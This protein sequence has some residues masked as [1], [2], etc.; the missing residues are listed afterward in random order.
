MSAFFSGMEIAF[1]SCNRVFLEIEKNKKG[2]IAKVLKF[3]TSKP[4]KFITTMLVGNNFCL[5]IYGIFMGD[6]IIEILFSDLNTGPLPF[7]ILFIQTLISTF[8]IL[9]TAEFLPKVFFQLYANQ[10]VKYFALPSSFFYTFFMPISLLI[11]KITD[12]SLKFF[13]NSKSDKI[14]LTFSKN[15]LGEYIE[16]QVEA[17]ENKDQL[18]SEIE[19]FQNALEFSE[20]KVREVMIPRAE[21]IGINKSENIL[22]LSALFESTGYSKIP[23]YDE[24]IDDVI[25]FVHA[26]E[27]LKKP[28]SIIEILIPIEY[29]H[30]PNLITDVLKKLTIK[31]KTI[32]V[33]LDEYGGTA[34]LLTVED[35]IEELF[36]EIE[37]EYDIIEH[38]E[39]KINVNSFEF[40]ARLEI[41]YLIRK[42]KL[43]LPQDENY[44]TLGGLIFHITGEIP[45]RDTTLSI[46]DLEIKV[47]SVLSNK[48]EKVAIKKVID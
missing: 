8:I 2:I 24:N 34:G 39:K 5:V 32:A 35:I 36:G 40:S 10:M 11:L 15:E 28:N 48:I 44:E 43:D 30:E 45:Q 7:N 47:V 13:S 41:D 17:V 12:S 19:F 29:V 37:D 1:I 14:Q 42:Y 38:Y 31:R 23:V 4:S 22:E 6:K 26:F 9:I 25:G 16:E 20:T 21:I 33:V 3:L 46:N 27:M 18:D